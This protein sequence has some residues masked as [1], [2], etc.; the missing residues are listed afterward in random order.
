MPAVGFAFGIDRIIEELKKKINVSDIENNID[1]YILC[2]NEEEKM[3]ALKISQNLRLNNI[4]TE[5]NT[6]NLS[7]KSQFKCADNLHAKFLLILNSNDLN[8]GLINVKD[9]ATK[10]EEKVDENEIVDYLLGRI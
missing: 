4:I 10:E 2:V 6:N 1:A 9:N 5:V 7:L 3:Q 8:K